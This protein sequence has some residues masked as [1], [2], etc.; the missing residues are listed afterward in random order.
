MQNTVDL[1]SDLGTDAREPLNLSVHLH[2]TLKWSWS[3]YAQKRW[4]IPT[5]VHLCEIIYRFSV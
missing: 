3:M 5:G 1:V 4:P 2:V